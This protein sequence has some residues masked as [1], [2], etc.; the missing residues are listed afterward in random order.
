MVQGADT[1]QEI[2]EETLVGLLNLLNINMVKLRWSGEEGQTVNVV[3]EWYEKLNE[4]LYI[5]SLGKTKPKEKSSEWVLY[6]KLS[7]FVHGS[8]VLRL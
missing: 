1:V 8:A 5:G 3:K 6:D 7:S 2:E 4:G